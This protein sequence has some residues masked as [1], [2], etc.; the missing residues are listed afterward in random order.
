MTPAPDEVKSALLALQAGLLVGMPTETVYGIAADALEEPA[1]E[2]LFLAKGRP[3]I[4]PVAILVGSV[5]QAQSIGRL[6]ATALA[7]AERHWPGA[8]TLV[9][10]RV[11]G[12]PQWIGDPDRGTV[13]LRVPDHPVALALLEGHGPLA[14]SSAN[15]SGQPPAVDAARARE[16]LGDMVSVY[17][18]GM[19][20]AGEPSTV[21]DVSVSH[22]R[23]LRRGPIDWNLA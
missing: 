3:G 16:V 6:D 20:G 21:V 15:R 1:V 2:R 12:L 10:G 8:L 18:E 11:D 19:V 17:L 14:V 7:A 5:E 4:N 22:P 23:V 9:V 13:G